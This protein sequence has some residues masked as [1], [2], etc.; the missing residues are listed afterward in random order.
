MR[1]TRI[2]PAGAAALL[3][4][5]TGVAVATPAAASTDQVWVQAV[6]RS[7]TDSPCPMNT[8]AEDAAGWT[9]WSP[10]YGQW[11]NG[12]TGGWV[13]Q[14]SIVWARGSDPR[15]PTTC[16]RGNSATFWAFTSDA[17]PPGT[18][19]YAEDTCTTPGVLS[20]PKWAVHAG[21][22][23]AAQAICDVRDPGG[24]AHNPGFGASAEFYYC[25]HG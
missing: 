13:C 17:L 25:E 12:G 3:V 1:I 7:T 5:G 16:V 22:D 2:V 24:V 14:R 18:T 4:A 10:S 11:M 23:Q 6:G 21:S 9:P 15:P 8:A 19:A 20:T